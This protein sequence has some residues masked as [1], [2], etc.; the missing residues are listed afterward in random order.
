VATAKVGSLSGPER[1]AILMVV[2]GEET[3]GGLLKKLPATSA[4]EVLAQVARLGEVDPRV[5]EQVLRDYYIDATRPEKQQGGAEIAR[6]LLART[7]I[8]REQHERIL[9]AGGDPVAQ[10]LAPLLATP[11][12]RLSEILA[13]EHAQTAALVLLHLDPRRAAQ[14]LEAMPSEVSKQV[15][16]RMAEVRPVRGE[17]LEEIVGGL[18]DQ[19]RHAASAPSPRAEVAGLERTAA[20]LQ[21]MPRGRM[22]QLLEGV[23]QSHPGQ[24]AKLRER[25]FTFESLLL[26]DDRGI[27]ELLRLVETRTLALALDGAPQELADKFLRN[28]SERAAAMLKEEMEYLGTVRPADREAPR[29]ELIRQALELEGQDKLVFAEGESSGDGR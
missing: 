29:A 3:A 17:M 16:A 27:Q 10:L 5:A 4:A 28:L 11:P 23:E 26:A 13:A 12:Q 20:V 8:P 2:L 21:A 18:E 24:A 15:I 19:V 9:G 14:V 6:R 7:E 22:R 25:I 1:A